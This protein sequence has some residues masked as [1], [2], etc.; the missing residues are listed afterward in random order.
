M[1][2]FSKLLVSLSYLVCGASS[3]VA[4]ETH[5]SFLPISEPEIPTVENAADWV[6]SEVDAFV[7]HTLE[8]K[9]L[10]PQKLA[11]RNTLIRRVAIDLIGLP[12]T[13]AQI[14]A[15]TSDGSPNATER[16]IDRFLASPH[17]GERWA[18]HWL[19]VARFGE[20]DG[21]LTV[22]EDKPRG[23]RWKYRD[24]TI[25]ALNA[26]LPFDRFVRYQFVDPTEA[27]AELG[28]LKQFIH[29]GTRL[30]RNADPNDKQHHRIDDMVATTGNA[31]L[32][33]TVGC[34]RCHDHPVDPISTR[35]YYE[36]SAVFFDQVNEEPKASKKAIPLKITEPHVLNKG[37]WSSPGDAVEPGYL[38]VLMK[39]PATHWQADEN[40]LGALAN[41]LTDLEHGAGHQLARVMVNRLWHHHF[42]RGLVS[43]PNDFGVL[44]AKPSHPELLDWLALRLIE[45][46]W[47]LKPMHR[48]IMNSSVYLQAG[49]SDLAQL[50]RDAENEWLWHYRPR[51]LESEAVR[52]NLLSV[53]GVLDLNMYGPSLSVG[54]YKKPVKDT[55]KHWRRSIYLLAH[56]TVPQATLNLFDPPVTERSLG[57]RTTSSSP[58]S[59]LFALNAPLV[60]DLSEHFAKR[61]IDEV[62]EKPDAQLERAYQLAFARPPLPE[63]REI[64]LSLLNSGSDRALI[65]FCHV[66]LGLNEFIYVH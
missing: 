46:E 2:R 35:E 16:M 42:G 8:Q 56:R 54:A 41:W 44:G 47:R 58:E 52:D 59:A 48:L 5:W 21:I 53:A 26:D 9:G 25:K 24:A 32:G 57:K 37:S 40:K 66:L 31:F 60:W 20:T 34:A 4:M 51:R 43:T 39:Q 64:G 61:L 45:N 17:Y 13:P 63:E 22:N 49:T 23:D 28:E 12:P 6:R 62:G 65:E 7:L 14:K 10:T 11:D 36:L 27:D 18:R 38:K 15:F 1:N 3:L 33:L 29:L 19:D 55:P 50:E 30:Q